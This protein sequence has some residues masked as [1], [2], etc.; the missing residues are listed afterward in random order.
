[1]TEEAISFG[2]EMYIT[3]SQ[4]EDK[5]WRRLQTISVEDVGFGDLNS[6]ILINTLNQMRQ[7]FP[8]NDG[9]R[10]LF[11]YTQFDISLQLKKIALVII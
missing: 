3:S 2:F 1:M 5:L 9:D 10:P 8:Y 4:F 6:P 7:N 11:L